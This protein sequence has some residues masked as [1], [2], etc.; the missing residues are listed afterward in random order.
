MYGST[1]MHTV[2]GALMA[3][4]DAILGRAKTAKHMWITWIKI[5]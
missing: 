5:Q 2:D 3:E 4:L 1:D